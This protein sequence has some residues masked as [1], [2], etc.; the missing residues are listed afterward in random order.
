MDSRDF[1]TMKPT[2]PDADMVLFIFEMGARIA[3]SYKILPV[4]DALPESSGEI[5]QSATRSDDVLDPV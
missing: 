2:E 1:G 5:L 3:P 4:S